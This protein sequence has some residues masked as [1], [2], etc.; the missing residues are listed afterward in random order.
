MH[1]RI[2]TAG[3]LA[4]VVG[5]LWT[6]LSQSAVPVRNELGYKEVPDEEAVLQLLD[7]GLPETGLYLLPGHSPPDSLF[8]ARYENGPIFRVHSLR[9]GAGGAP[10][11]I[12]SILGF[13]IAPLIPAWFLW[14][15]CRYGRPGFAARVGVVSLFGIFL[16]LA[17]HLQ[18]WGMELY[19]LSYS[20]FL[21]VNGLI[22]WTL[23]GIVLAWR[24]TP[25][26][27]SSGAS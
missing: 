11:V 24:I 12:V 9:S 19:P 10:H 5:L 27:V 20:L 1:R 18:L 23:V 8:R 15:L 16:A 2:V 17:A 7:R 25:D 14:G 13:L 22:G 3:L 21:A 6:A 26:V 4:G